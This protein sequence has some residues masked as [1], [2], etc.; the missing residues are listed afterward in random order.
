MLD[1]K[2]QEIESKRTG[3]TPADD[4]S[5]RPAF[6]TVNIKPSRNRRIGRVIAFSIDETS[7]QMA[8][9]S[10]LGSRRRV[11]D[12]Q[13]V[14]IKHDD[15]GE[16]TSAAFISDTCSQFV[17]EYSGY[18]ST[19]RLT[20]S[21]E[22]TAHRIFFMPILKKRDLDSAIA[23]EIRR[24]I[25]FPPEDCYYDYRRLFKVTS[26]T[27]QRYR[28][29]LHA[30]TK[31]YIS[32]QLKPFDEYGI[33]VSNIYMA[34]GVVGLLLEDLPDYDANRYYTLVNIKRNESEISFYRGS[35]LEFSHVVSTGSLMLGGGDATRFDFFAE[36]LATEIQTALDYYTGQYSRNFA[37]QIYVQGDLSYSE[38]L[39]ELLNGR[40]SFTF[41]NFPT[42]QLRSIKAPDEV[43]DEVLSVCLPVLAAATC[44]TDLGNLLPP[45]GR[46]RLFFQKL[47][48][49]ATA[50]TILLVIGLVIGWLFMKQ[51]SDAQ[52]V[53][54]RQLTRQIERIEESPGFHTYNILKRQI[55][56]DRKYLDQT[57]ELPSYFHLNLK[58][59]SRLTPKAIELYNLDLDLEN[60]GPNLQL[61][62]IATGTAM[63]PEI[64]LVEYVENLNSSAFY[65]DVRIIRH[66]KKNEKGAFRIDFVLSAKAVI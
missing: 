21:G 7:I 15:T 33:E 29:A 20:I 52:E 57:R 11:L 19:F 53:G 43:P 18:H 66:V 32:R 59:L 3:D 30:A 44:Q 38:D 17:R 48:I 23:F 8:A 58:E 50:L 62:G 25:P 40:S 16:D 60:D 42:G 34:Q 9:V 5:G 61:Q 63:P 41:R 49:G 2:S 54:L 4:S 28:V 1:L 56:I 27:T 51:R 55:A 46:K 24:Q 26:D 37:S 22:Q 47:E 6:E 35:L 36:S 31:R 14:Y 10:H 65:D 13:K 12:I 39:I 45:E 64:T